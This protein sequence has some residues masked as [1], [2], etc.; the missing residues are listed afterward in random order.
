VRAGVLT[1]L[2]TKITAFWEIAMNVSKEPD[3]SIFREEHMNVHRQR[4]DREG[5]RGQNEPTGST[6]GFVSSF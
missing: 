4:Y 6:L 5:R 1:G 2:H 3:A